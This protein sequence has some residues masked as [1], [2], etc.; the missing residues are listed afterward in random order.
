MIDREGML[1]RLSTLLPPGIELGE[2][3]GDDLATGSVEPDFDGQLLNLQAK[4]TAAA[5]GIEIVSF[6]MTIAANTPKGHLEARSMGFNSGADLEVTSSLWNEWTTGRYKGAYLLL[7][8][9][10]ITENQAGTFWAGENFEFT[11]P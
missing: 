4:L 5:P 7:A 3:G 6:G 8:F 11:V 2:L 1:A 10:K 9:V